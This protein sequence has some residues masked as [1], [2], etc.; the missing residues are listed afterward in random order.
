M[1]QQN[2]AVLP[3]EDIQ[4]LATSHNLQGPCP[5]LPAA[6]AWITDSFLT[7]LPNFA[8]APL[9][10]SLYA[11]A[12]TIL[13]KHK[14]AQ[15]MRL[16]KILYSS[17]SGSKPEAFQWSRSPYLSCTSYSDLTS[18]YSAHSQAIQGPSLSS[19]RQ[20]PL[21]LSPYC[22]Q[23]A[24][25]SALSCSECSSLSCQHGSLNSFRS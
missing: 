10:P 16:L 4:S 23:Q 11:A 3:S 24:S 25:M 8:L 17:H 1:H 19:Y 6:S 7:G 5:G 21:P 2:P 20:Q 13:L 14:S 18:C 9:Q 22:S 12:K 15:V